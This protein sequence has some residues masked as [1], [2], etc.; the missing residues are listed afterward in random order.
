MAII[1]LIKNGEIYAP[2]YFGKKDILL[3]GEKIGYI[4]D[5]INIPRDFVD[6]DIIDGTGKYVVPGFLDSHVHICV[7]GERED[8]K[9]AHQKYS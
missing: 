5:Q 9:L 3:V 6:I 7:G 1:K 2:N 8:L 4:K